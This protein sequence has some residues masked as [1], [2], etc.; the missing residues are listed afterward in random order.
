[1]MLFFLCSDVR[2][3]I[4]IGRD[5][6]LTK[7]FTPVQVLSSS[8]VFKPVADVNAADAVLMSSSENPTADANVTTRRGLLGEPD[9][10]RMGYSGFEGVSGANV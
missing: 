9:E 4:I 2:A 1:M 3:G 10:R 5:A 8:A 6:C 7:A